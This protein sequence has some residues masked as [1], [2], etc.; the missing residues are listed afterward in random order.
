MRALR[1][2]RAQR[3]GNARS[4]RKTRALREKRAQPGSTQK[5]HGEKFLRAG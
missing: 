1:E 3:E 2:I 4:R 5:K